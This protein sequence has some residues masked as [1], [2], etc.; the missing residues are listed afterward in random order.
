[1]K[2]SY[3]KLNRQNSQLIVR[4]ERRTGWSGRGFGMLPGQL[5]ERRREKL[6]SGQSSRQCPARLTH[7]R[8]TQIQL[9]SDGRGWPGLI[10]GLYRT[11]SGTTNVDYPRRLELP[12]LRAKLR[13]VCKIFYLVHNAY[14]MDMCLKAFES[15]A[16]K[17]LI[18]CSLKQASERAGK[19]HPWHTG[20]KLKTDSAKRTRTNRRK[21][22]PE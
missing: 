19:R 10:D 1:M 16:R 11:L 12:K 5:A 15:T 13:T 6:W 17:L 22:W 14:D 3:G 18:P 8:C 9:G 7:L 20:P 2:E 4:K 21:G